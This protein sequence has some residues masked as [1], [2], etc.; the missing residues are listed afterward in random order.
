MTSLLIHAVVVEALEACPW[1]GGPEAA[2]V[3]QY[4]PAASLIGL[5]L[6]TDPPRL[7]WCPHGWL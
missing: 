7:A 3:P 5:Q 2:A 6:L 1:L 4:C